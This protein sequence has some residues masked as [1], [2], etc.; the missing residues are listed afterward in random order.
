[1]INASAKY[2]TRLALVPLEPAVLL[3][4]VI[5]V[6]AVVV[7][8]FAVPALNT[9][10]VPPPAAAPTVANRC[11]CPGSVTVAVCV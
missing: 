6:V 8:Q 10:A 7:S 4:T 11:K 3:D 9:V 5:P 2:G 1:M